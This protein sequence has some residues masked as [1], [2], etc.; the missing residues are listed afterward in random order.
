[1]ST[2]HGAA[3]VAP[4]IPGCASRG[5]A[6]AAHDMAMLAGG[7]LDIT[8]VGW[9]STGATSSSWARS[10]FVYARIGLQILRRA[11]LNTDQVWASVVLA[12]LVTLTS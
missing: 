12:G 9:L 8:A 10:P 2:A 6:A 1:M 3:L 11:W 7:P 5:A 4:V